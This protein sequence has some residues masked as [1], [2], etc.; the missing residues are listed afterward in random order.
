MGGKAKPETQLQCICCGIFI[1]FE[2]NDLKFVPRLV[3]V[4]LVLI[5]CA[6]NCVSGFKVSISAR[7]PAK[8]VSR[9]RRGLTLTRITHVVRDG[10]IIIVTLVTALVT[11]YGP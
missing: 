7:E 11:Y 10:S 2:R 8:S 6:F 3:V 5:T 4:F 9:E 1:I